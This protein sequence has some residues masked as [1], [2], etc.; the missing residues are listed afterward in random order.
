MYVY[1]LSDIERA[2]YSHVVPTCRIPSCYNRLD[3]SE[4]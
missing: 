1:E 3:E 2:M 4:K